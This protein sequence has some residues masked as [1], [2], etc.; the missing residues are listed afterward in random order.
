MSAISLIWKPSGDPTPV[1]L[2]RAV[3]SALEEYGPGRQL[4]WG[5]PRIALGTSLL[6]SLPEDRFDSQP[7]WSE[8]RA[9]C[10]VADIRLDNRADLAR[11]L[12]LIHP[13]QLPDSAFLM[14]AWL[15]WGAS[16]VD[17]L[18][19]GYAFAI[20]TPSRQEVFAARDHTGERPL[21]YHRGQNLFALA[22]MPKGLLAIPGVPRGFQQ[23]NLAI[24]LAGLT[25]ARDTT[26]YAGI[27]RL[28]PGHFLRFT[29]HTFECRQYW[30]PANAAPTRYQRDQDYAEAL[31]ELL[32]RATE[33]RLRSIKP[34]GAFLSAGLDSSS[35][36]ASAA[37]LLAAQGK[38]LAAFTAVPRP[39]FNGLSNPWHLPSEAEGAADVAR[40]YPNIQ[41]I[42][43]DS[44]GY[45]LLPTLQAWT[46]AL[47]DPFPNVINSLWI[48]AIL[49]QA[50][51][52]G[53]GVMLEGAAGNGTITWN[54][55]GILSQFFRRGHWLQLA[56]TTR[57]LHRHGALSLKT[58]ARFATRTL[59]PRSL[60]RSLVPAK[61]LDGL[62]DCLLNPEW[63]DRYQIQRK[64][65]D[66]IYFPPTDLIREQSDLFESSDVG[67]IHAAAQAVTQVELRDPT[68]DKRIY[69]FC[70]SIPREQYIVGRHSRSLIRR[71]M[72][73]RLPPSTVARY[74]RGQQ[75]A[76]WYL[77]AADALPELRAE[78]ARLT[79]SP[80]ASQALDLPAIQSLLDHWPQS[81]FHT[82]HVALRWHFW[83][84]RAFSMGYFLRSHDP[85]AAETKAPPATHL[86]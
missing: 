37:R 21:F 17:H 52:R 35:V 36:T 4:F 39:D 19:G 24:W 68:A 56:R 16:C 81:G 15:R 76:D 49:D 69:D 23:P 54:S 67:P 30:H 7:L 22:S 12:N 77:S 50:R 75:G 5:D 59:I 13:E 57:S 40:L 2:H 80:A 32:D 73:D 85:S 53:I 9:C 3:L 42:T 46:D 18:L 44:N 74:T 58:A 79:Q 27:E 41:H 6:P 38:S 61:N 65:F 29:P 20:W 64:L 47:D 48:T 82:D 43:V 84:M 33:A 51:Q 1:I 60:T 71:A 11:E 26:L 34:T 45:N 31:V 10:L 83:L 78:V 86:N 63:K 25:P 14:A 62:F 28:P 55:W 70:F 8:D 72:K 66:S